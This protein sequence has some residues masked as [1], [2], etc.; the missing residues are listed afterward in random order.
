MIRQFRAFLATALG[1]AAS[2]LAAAPIPAAPMDP[3][4]VAKWR[5]D[6]AF[7]A[8]SVPPG[9]RASITRAPASGIAPPSIP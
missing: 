9:I 2:C 6:L 8:D 7:M 4:W 3:A 5:A 1:V